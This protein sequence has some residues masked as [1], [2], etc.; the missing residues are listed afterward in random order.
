[1]LTA[2]D[3]VVG[4]PAGTGAIYYQFTGLPT[5]SFRIKAALDVIY[6]TS[7]A[8]F[9]PTYHASSLYWN[10]A[11]VINHVSGASDINKNITLDRGIVS[12]GPGFIEG[13]VTTGANKGT[14]SS[15]PAI[16]LR[17]FLL[18]ATYQIVQMTQ[19]DND[20]HYAFANLPV[21]QTYTVFPE[22]LSYATTAYTGITLT[23]TAPG[24]AVAHFEQRTISKKIVPFVQSVNPNLNNEPMVTAFPNPTAGNLNIIWNNANYGKGFVAITDLS[25]RELL[26]KDINMA[27]NGTEHIDLT[28]FNNGLF[29]LQI[30]AGNYQYNSIVQV[31]H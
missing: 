19:T 16:G 3:S 6:P 27:N 21:G 26:R 23:S 2:V 24:M 25:G 15:S 4:M 20:G 29:L 9:M 17:V 8:G 5:D 10:T 1:M 12:A 28:T 31:Q 30:K 13:D 18:N 22:E 14:A 11:S 7:Y